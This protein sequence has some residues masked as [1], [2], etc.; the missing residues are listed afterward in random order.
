MDR[1]D[2]EDGDLMATINVDSG[3]IELEVQVNPEVEVSVEVVEIM[4]VLVEVMGTGPQG[5]P[6]SPGSPAPVVV[7]TQAAYDA[8]PVK[9]PLT[10]YF[11]I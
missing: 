1:L 6:G 10:V 7:M 4:P 9:D 11:I 3:I 8:L 5:P 2:L